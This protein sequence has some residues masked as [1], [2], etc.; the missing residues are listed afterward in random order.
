MNTRFTYL[1]ASC[2]LA[3]GLP[4]EVA[5][6]PSSSANYLAGGSSNQYH[7]YIFEQSTEVLMPSW[8]IYLTDNRIRSFPVRYGSFKHQPRWSEIYADFGER[9]GVAVLADMRRKTLVVTWA[10]EFKTPGLHYVQSNVRYE[11]ERYGWDE[12]LA[13]AKNTQLEY[14]H[15]RKLDIQQAEVQ[16]QNKYNAELYAHK[17]KLSE[18]SE[19]KDRIRDR[20]LF[21]TVQNLEKDYELKRSR[22]ESDYAMKRLELKELKEIQ[23]AHYKMDQEE[24][25]EQFS[26][27]VS[28]QNNQFAE[29]MVDLQIQYELD[30]RQLNADRANIAAIQAKLKSKIADYEKKYRQATITKETFDTELAKIEKDSKKLDS[31]KAALVKREKQLEAEYQKR[32][33]DL[34]S[35]IVA[36]KKSLNDEVIAMKTDLAQ[37][38]TD[39]K[40]SVDSQISEKANQLDMQREA[41]VKQEAELFSFKNKYYPEY[42]RQIQSGLASPAIEHFLKD[43]WDYELLWD[44]SFAPKNLRGKIA[45]K[46]GLKFTGNKL[47]TDLEEIVCHL[48][49]F[50]PNVV[51]NPRVY[52]RDR[53]VSIRV[54]TADSL[55]RNDFLQ[56]CK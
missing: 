55:T 49:K 10:D 7:D 34:E 38:K 16:R 22:L 4:A 25:K 23:M 19:M 42:N 41:L 1:I 15:Q 37:F 28:Q 47:E 24:L 45:F 40:K 21:Q 52:L 53:V 29:R 20:T 32:N 6:T 56:Q 2:C 17:L 3:L 8:D 27:L 54:D 12:L 33:S 43:E 35:E 13:A 31:D 50:T 39:Y 48:A 51:F 14:D 9:F 5:A 30:T 36:R 11:R 46:H 26:Q 44:D 18:Q